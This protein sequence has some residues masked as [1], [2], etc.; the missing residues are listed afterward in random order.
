MKLVVTKVERSVDWFERLKVNVHL[1]RDA[2]SFQVSNVNESFWSNHTIL[3]SA[4]QQKTSCEKF[5]VHKSVIDI[6]TL[7][8]RAVDMEDYATVRRIK[9]EQC[10]QLATFKTDAN[11]VSNLD[12]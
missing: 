1:Q 5:I 3:F 10:V 7:Q 9:L 11:Q 12:S 6:G 8:E 4:Y 2:K